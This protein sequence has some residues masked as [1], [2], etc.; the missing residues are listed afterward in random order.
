METAG[1]RRLSLST[2]LRSVRITRRGVLPAGVSAMRDPG[3][4]RPGPTL[5]DGGP[6]LYRADSDFD[7]VVSP[8]LTPR[9][10][11]ANSESSSTAWSRPSRRRVS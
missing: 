5:L 8:E 7:H 3:S 2:S 4:H 10:C 9:L 1:R 11:G 6:P